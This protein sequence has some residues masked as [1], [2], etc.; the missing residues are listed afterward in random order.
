MNIEIY[1]KTL[2]IVFGSLFILYGI[3]IAPIVNKLNKILAELLILNKNYDKD[4]EKLNYTTKNYHKET[5]EL[6]YTTKNYLRGIGQ[7]V[8]KIRKLLEKQDKE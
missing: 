1:V 6:G 4:N 2:V 7:E 5:D 3:L 8:L